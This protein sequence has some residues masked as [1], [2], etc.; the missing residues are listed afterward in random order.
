MDRFSRETLLT[1]AVA[2]PYGRYENRAVCVTHLPHATAVLKLD[3]SKVGAQGEAK[4]S[5]FHHV[6]KYFD[7]DGQRAKAEKVNEQAV[8]MRR[9]LLG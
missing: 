3:V 9:R 4:A 2:F 1:V 6:A 5:S 7:F 8:E